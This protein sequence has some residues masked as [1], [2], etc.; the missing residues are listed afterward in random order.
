MTHEIRLANSYAQGLGVEKS[1]VNA[2]KWYAKAATEGN[3]ESLGACRT[4]DMVA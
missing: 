3:L 1:D 4:I 2:F